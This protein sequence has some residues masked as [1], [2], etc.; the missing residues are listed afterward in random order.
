LRFKTAGQTGSNGGIFEL[1]M[2]DNMA[3]ISSMHGRRLLIISL[4][5][6]LLLAVAL[7]WGLRKQSVR[8]RQMKLAAEQQDVRVKT[9]VVIRRQFFS[10]QQVE[11]DDYRK[12]IGNLREIGC[13]EQTIRDII[14]ADV[15]GLYA[16]KRATEVVSPGQ[17]WWRSQPDS[18]VVR[19]AT[20]RIREL[21]DERR[22][23]LTSL[24]GL[25]W[26]S[27]D[28]V[29]LPRPSRSSVALDGEVLGVLPDDVK[30]TVQQIVA[31]FQ[32]QV[33]D[34]RESQDGQ[35]GTRDPAALSALNRQL[36]KDLAQVLS[37]QQLEEFLLRYSTTAAS[38]R[39]ELG[40]LKYFDVTPE[41]FRA[42]FRANDRMNQQLQGLLGTSDEG[43][44]GQRAAFERQREDAIRQALGRERYAEYRMLQEQTY[45]D[46]VASAQQANSPASTPTLYEINQATAEEIARIHANESLTD[47]QR[48]I[49]LK[50]TELE[51][52]KAAAAA[53][54]E[55]LPPEPVPITTSPRQPPGAA[56]LLGPNETVNSIALLYGISPAELRSA[57]PSLNMDRLKAG[58]S[59][60]IPFKYPPQA[61]LPH[62]Q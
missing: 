3:E 21:E 30:K 32:D 27:G 53:L 34:W 57:N 37:P 2:S 18:N 61:V 59:V 6:N 35:N 43:S 12:Y 39:G 55:D 40:R 15:N 62:N 29:N 8:V 16:K 28:L 50:R 36:R 58:D 60:N 11:S 25:G 23:L 41:E 48:A 4:V 7:L 17:Q 20:A 47:A 52:L 44:S 33:Q 31:R 13:P 46:A 10:W 1:A 14:I 26:E 5:A 19:A 45:R 51:Q 9:N 54:G 22:A 42:I 38:L 24:L 49:E 56:H